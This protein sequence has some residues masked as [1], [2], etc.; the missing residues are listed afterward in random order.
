MLKGCF[1]II[2]LQVKF[3][4]KFKKTLA[5]SLEFQITYSYLVSAPLHH[6]TMDQGGFL[7]IINATSKALKV[8]NT[9]STQMNV[10]IFG[11]IPSQSQKK[12]HIEYHSEDN[13]E[14]CAG[15][16]TFQLQDTDESF[17]VLCCW[18][19]NEAECGLKVDWSGITASNYQVFPPP[20]DDGG[21]GKIGWIHDG[22][23][24]LLIMENE[25]APSISAHLPGE[26]SIVSSQTIIESPLTLLY[27]GSWMEHYNG[28]L[29]KLTLAEMTLPGTH[30]SGTYYPES[31]VGSWIKT[32]E[33]SLAQQLNH[34]IRALDLCIGQ[35]SP[36]DYVICHEGWC[37]SYSLAGAL[38]EVTDFIEKTGKEIIILDF[39]HFVNF[40]NE[41]FDYSLLKQQIMSDLSDYYLPV[42]NA[43]DPLE[44]IWSSSEGQKRRV[45]VAWNADNP[46]SYM[47]PGV[48]QKS[49]SN[50]YSPSSLYKSI[51]NDM[52]NPPSG[53]WAVCS[54]MAGITPLFHA[55]SISPTITNWYFGGSKFCERANIISVDFFEKYTNVV[56]ASIV[57]SLLKA[58]KKI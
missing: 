36:G 55:V 45:V 30:N 6:S 43:G 31:A 18:P 32:Q 34:G 13:A 7:W 11:A 10:W 57:S 52:L 16:A 33:L 39:H 12:F 42:S 40:G 1:Q 29:G 53:V 4:K 37:T 26:D 46:D 15:E 22:S 50:A 35:N 24:S 56:Q 19:L 28:V 44:I 25:I 23:V 2:L 20:V 41:N 54:V 9:S 48:N 17:K 58:G 38:K 47:W 27:G 49:Y 8:V 3:K 14:A 5:N 21:F 51:K